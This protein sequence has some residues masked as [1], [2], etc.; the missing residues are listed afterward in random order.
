[1]FKKIV[2]PLDGSAFA[3]HALGPALTL[4]RC[5]SAEMILLR[6]I[7]LGDVAKRVFGGYRY[8]WE[9]WESSLA[10]QRSEAERYL[11][12]VLISRDCAGLRIHPKV[13]VSRPAADVADTIIDVASA[14]EADLIV[15]TTHGRS[16]LQRWLR[17]SI[18]EK[19]IRS[20]CCPVLIA[21]SQRAGQKAYDERLHERVPSDP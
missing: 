4:A 13:V 17:D 12:S 5:G 14:D 21:H 11:S 1:M 15:L 2:V 6:V 20:G 8:R 18:S 3:E 9:G 19:V 7:L 16:G 10:Q